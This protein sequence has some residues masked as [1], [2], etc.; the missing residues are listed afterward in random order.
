MNIV[1][2]LLQPHSGIF[3]G[4]ELEIENNEIIAE[5]KRIFHAIMRYAILTFDLNYETWLD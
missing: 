3:N 4:I 1:I 5:N 2:D